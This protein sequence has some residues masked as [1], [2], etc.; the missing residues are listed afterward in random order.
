MKNK[1]V[2]YCRTSVNNSYFA[3][4]TGIC[5]TIEGVMFVKNDA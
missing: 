3:C 2:T 5:L 4:G 1:N